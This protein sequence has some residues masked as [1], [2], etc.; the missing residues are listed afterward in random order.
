MNRSARSV[1]RSIVA[2]VMLLTLTGMLAQPATMSRAQ[3][4][5]P[6]PPT[7]TAVSTD[8]AQDDNLSSRPGI[9]IVNPDGT[10][11]FQPLE[12]KPQVNVP[13]Q[14]SLPASQAPPSGDPAVE[15][16]AQVAPQAVSASPLLVNIVSSPTVRA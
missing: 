14:E 9:V 3:Q 2:L 8:P 15:P 13:A 10:Y 1:G 6:P 4:S 7:P 12:S 5:T 11:S 16:Q